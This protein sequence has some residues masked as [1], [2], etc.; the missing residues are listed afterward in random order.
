[1]WQSHHVNTFNKSCTIYLL[2]QE[3]SQQLHSVRLAVQVPL[4]IAHT[5]CWINFKWESSH[6]RPLRGRVRQQVF[7]IFLD[8]AVFQKTVSIFI[9]CQI[10]VRSNFSIEILNIL[11]EGTLKRTGS[12]WFQ[13][14]IHSTYFLLSWSATIIVYNILT[15]RLFLRI[16]TPPWWLNVA[17][18]RLLHVMHVS[19]EIA[20]VNSNRAVI[21]S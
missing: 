20:F 11:T 2:R 12:I 1:M 13:E 14:N 6:W 3:K 18:H 19:Q 17:S 8:Q 21:A 7:L 16:L 9:S 10:C 4:R 5:L 15:Q